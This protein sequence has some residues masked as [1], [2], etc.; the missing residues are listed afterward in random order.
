VKGL[1]YFQKNQLKIK[2]F[3]KKLYNFDQPWN[4]LR[5]CSDFVELKYNFFYKILI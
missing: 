2:N 1:G 5:F 3:G 4:P